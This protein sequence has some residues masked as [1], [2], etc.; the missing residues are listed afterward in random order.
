[1]SI[2]ALQIQLLERY[3]LG[4]AVFLQVVGCYNESKRHRAM[5]DDQ[6]YRERTRIEGSAASSKLMGRDAYWYFVDIVL[7]FVEASQMI[8]Q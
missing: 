3:F 8:S 2:N 7:H 1:M 4:H 5:R 6:D